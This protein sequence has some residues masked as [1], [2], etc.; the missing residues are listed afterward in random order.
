MIW[1]LLVAATVSTLDSPS[2]ATSDHPTPSFH[3]L[4]LRQ[5]VPW[6]AM[7]LCAQLATQRGFVQN[8]R[9][10]TMKAG[11]EILERVPGR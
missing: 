8:G 11:T 9:P 2:C 6:S 1:R 3:Q 5:V 4:P 7:L 10:D